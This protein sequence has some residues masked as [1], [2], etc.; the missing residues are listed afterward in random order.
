MSGVSSKFYGR[1]LRVVAGGI[2]AV[3]ALLIGAGPASA[4]SAHP[5]VK[6]HIDVVAASS[7]HIRV[8]GWTFDPV[9]SAKS[10]SVNVVVDGLMAAL[11]VAGNARADVNRV[12][13]VTGRH[14]YS[15][16]VAAKPGAHR[17]CV[18]AMPIAD[19][20]GSPVVLGCRTV[21]VR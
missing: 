15:T 14:G 18:I 17:V 2:V 8:S 9:R 21:Q 4:A 12:F 11:P 7:G 5:A 6:G 13:K 3:A 20:K 1:S 10:N 16:T 19:T